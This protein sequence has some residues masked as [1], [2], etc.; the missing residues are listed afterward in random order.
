LRLEVVQSEQEGLKGEK[1]HL[2]LELQETKQLQ[3]IY[4]KKCA[5]LLEELNSVNQD[6]Q[7]S[8]REIIGFNEVKREREERI[9]KLKTELRELK[10][11]HEELDLKHGALKV[12]YEKASEQ[13]ATTKK[14]LD[15]VIEKLHITNKVRH[16]TEVK[17]NDQLDRAKQLNQVIKDKEEL[18]AKRAVEIDEQ[19]KKIVELE[20]QNEA[21]EIKKAGVE[22]QLELTKKQLNEK[23]AYLNEMLA[24][25]KDNREMWIERYEKEQK[26]HT[27]TNAQLLQARS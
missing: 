6:F 2:E 24:G 22:R 16:E 8:K 3:S 21:I 12:N 14:D 5:S 17:L 11:A 19:D 1:Q 20:R 10:V 25:E 13:A 4:E 23:I 15:D 27:A 7:E 26:E 9:D 18:L